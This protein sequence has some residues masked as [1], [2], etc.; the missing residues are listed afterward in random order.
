[1]PSREAELSYFFMIMGNLAKAGD[2]PEALAECVDDLEALATH[3]GVA[4]IRRRAAAAAEQASAHL[5]DLQATRFG[6]AG[7]SVVML[8]AD[9]PANLN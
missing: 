6:Y 5:A 9:A 3:S 7:P 1:M 4:R 8:R 2:N